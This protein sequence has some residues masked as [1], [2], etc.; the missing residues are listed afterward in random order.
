VSEQGRVSH[1]EQRDTRSRESAVREQAEIDR[2]A[3]TGAREHAKTE[4]DAA[5]D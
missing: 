5:R 2:E 4:P 3:A 1:A